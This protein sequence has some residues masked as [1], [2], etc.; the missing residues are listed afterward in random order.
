MTV[1]VQMFSY[2]AFAL[3]RPGIVAAEDPVA[4]PA[5]NGTASPTGAGGHT[6]TFDPVSCTWENQYFSWNPVSKVYTAKYS[7]APVF[8]AATNTMDT[9]VWAYSPAA[10]QYTARV[11]S[12]AIATP[13]PSADGTSS[14]A[15][16]TAASSGASTAAEQGS[17][18]VSNTGT[19]SN[20]QAQGNNTTNANIGESHDASV[21][22]TINSS[23]TSGV[24][25]IL[26]N[27]FAGDAVS[28]AADATANIINMIQSLWRPAFGSLAS[29][30]ANLYNEYFGDLLFDPGSIFNTGTDS[31]NTIDNQNNTNLTINREDDASI[32]NNLNLAAQSGDANNNG[33][34]TTGSATSGD[35]GAVA[36]I[37]NMINS[38]INAG[39]S[40][41]GAIN[42]YGDLTGDILLPDG[43][44]A[45]I[46][47]TG[48]DSTNTIDQANNSDVNANNTTNN[49]ITNNTDLAATSGNAVI[50]GNTRAGSAQTGDANT[51]VQE[52]NFIG[53]HLAGTKGLLVF[54]N[55]LGNWVGMLFGGLGSSTIQDTG[56]G[57][58]NA[59][60]STNDVGA[61][62]TTNQDYS[63]T[64]NLNLRAESGDAN[65]IGNTNAGDATT[66]DA[67]VAANMLN[68]IDSSIN[69]SDWFGVLFINVF[70]NWTG[71]FGVDTEAGGTAAS[72]SASSQTDTGALPNPVATF[73]FISGSSVN[74]SQGQQ[75]QDEPDG[76]VAT[77]VADSG[78]KDDTPVGGT[79]KGDDTKPTNPVANKSAALDSEDSLSK[80]I[81]PAG[82]LM[83][84]ITLLGVERLLSRRQL[85]LT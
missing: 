49:S 24:A 52:M 42:L 16:S 55:V 47:G 62:I 51:N 19:G 5:V 29:F 1:T 69:F 48:T 65:V 44:L 18:T 57:S 4:C 13:A 82:G 30:T 58:N 41:M 79:V 37:V 7:Q 73:A 67:S 25:S 81:V 63:I 77:A 20:N 85:R 83:G 61:D 53:R 10:G 9:T 34:T 68:M 35:A 11:T 15:N 59:I 27:T 38:Y 43:L 12:V 23:A 64:N 36:N 32:V 46:F 6:F 80:W 72:R 56:T 45:Q 70:G 26:G 40:F 2:S 75:S 22:N 33:N 71:S 78:E 3:L 54:V 17:S 60:N 21:E 50:E 28:G 39:Q 14:A 84:A 31:N 66:G 74:T 8:N 76:L